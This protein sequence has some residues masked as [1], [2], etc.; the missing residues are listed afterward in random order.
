[1]LSTMYDRQ[2]Q[3]FCY[4]ASFPFEIFA[5]ILSPKPRFPERKKLFPPL[6]VRM[7]TVIVCQ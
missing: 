6:A 2:K 5:E 1:M 4:F 3:L 7:T